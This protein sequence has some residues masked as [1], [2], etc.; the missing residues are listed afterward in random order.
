MKEIERVLLSEEEIAARI[1]EMGREITRDYQGEEVILVC[2]MKG[3][4]V[5]TADLMRELELPCV[6][7]FMQVSSYGNAAHSSGAVFVKKELEEDISGR[8]VLLVED[9][10]DS[11][12]TLRHLQEFLKKRGA[13]S[14][15][16]AALLNKPARHV[17][18]IEAD[19]I[20]FEIEDEFVVGYG[21]DFAQKYR[22]LPYIGVLK[23]EV[24]ESV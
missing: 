23:R 7:D 15:R 9:I 19:Y 21:L 2:I 13:K 1:N 17:T 24:Y 16:I 8:N 18:Q 11:G 3:S 12:R 22:N 14:V 20:G 6:L 10:I 4:L 5:F